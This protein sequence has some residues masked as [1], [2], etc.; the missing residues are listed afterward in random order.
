V[1]PE[2]IEFWQGGEMRLH[3]RFSYLRS[4]DGSDS[5]EIGRLSP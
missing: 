4:E 3:D 5:W 1:V 2:E